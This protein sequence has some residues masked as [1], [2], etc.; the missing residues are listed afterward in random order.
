MAKRIRRTVEQLD[1][2]QAP[3]LRCS[4]SLGLAEAVD[5]DTSLREWIESAD[6]ALYRAKQ[7][8]RNRTA[9][10]NETD[11]GNVSLG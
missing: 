5:A 10:E 7:A 3:G 8:G 2:S 6:R 9:S 11:L 4:I 1:L